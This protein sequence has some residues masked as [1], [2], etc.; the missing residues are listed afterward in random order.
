MSNE[1]N[2]KANKFWNDFYENKDQ[3][4]SG[5]VNPHLVR[6]I[7]TLEPGSALD[8]GCGEGG[9]AIWLASRGWHVTAADI[10]EVALNRTKV[11]AEKQQVGNL[12]TLD[13]H[14]FEM[15]F[16]AGKFDLVSAQFL[17]SP[18][19]FQRQSVLQKAAAAVSLN[20]ILLIVEHGGVPS[21][22]EHTDHVFPSVE[23][24]YANLELDR[25]KWEAVEVASLKRGINGPS[26]EPATIIDNVIVVKRIA[27]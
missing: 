11:L 19:E 23:E 2:K 16:P 15:S 5:N 1:R 27:S 8:L 26:G 13:Q 20:G 24:T 17:Q 9:D 14:D 18:L 4:W 22:S 6:I 21:F 3:I 7:E 12:V 10:S 25:S